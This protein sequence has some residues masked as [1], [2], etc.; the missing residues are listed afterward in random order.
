MAGP[1][2]LNIGLPYDPTVPLLGVYPK[3]LKAE[4]WT[5]I[6]P[7]FIRALFTVVN[8]WKQP[9]ISVNSEIDKCVI[10]ILIQWNIIVLKR[11]EI[12]THATTWITLEDIILSQTQT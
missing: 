6:F 4:T 3:E 2:K 8:R 11:K 9:H 5:E 1:E 10:H 12:L 7:M